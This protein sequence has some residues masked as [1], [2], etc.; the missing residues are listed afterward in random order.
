MAN[1]APTQ[2]DVRKAR[3]AGFKNSINHLPTDKRDALYNRYQQQDAR[4]E[5]NI[6]G[7]VSQIR[8]AK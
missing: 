3:H 8:S 4:R 2:E 7:F 1:N 6:S 5:K